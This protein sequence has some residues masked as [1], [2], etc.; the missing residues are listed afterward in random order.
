MSHDTPIRFASSVLLVAASWTLWG[1]APIIAPERAL[2]AIDYEQVPTAAAPVAADFELIC[3][4]EF[5]AVQVA[6]PISNL[7]IA[8][9]LEASGLFSTARPGLGRRPY[10]LTFVLSESEGPIN[11]IVWLSLLT[12]GLVPMPTAWE[13]G[14]AGSLSGPG[15]QTPSDLSLH[16][17]LRELGLESTELPPLPKSFA[18]TSGAYQ[19]VVTAWWP[20]FTPVSDMFM[21]P[22]R[23]RRRKV[24]EI[25]G[26]LYAEL[27]LEFLIDVGREGISSAV[28]VL[29]EDSDRSPE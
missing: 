5:G 4:D 21:G 7:D 17:R 29:V 13:L 20:Y 10:H 16:E 19:N 23:E 11:H 22:T 8:E 26:K 27:I 25:Y 15:G 1:C 6:C 18:I 3:L 24:R 9:L 12:A 2:G 14:L 28:D